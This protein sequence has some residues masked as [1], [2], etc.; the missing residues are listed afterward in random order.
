[1]KTRII[2][3][4]IAFITFNI[5]NTEAQCVKNNAFG[6]GEELEFTG[7]YNWGFIW[8]NAGKININVS[9]TNFQGK[10]AYQIKGAAKNASAFEVF[11]KLRDTL[12]TVVDKYNLAPYSLDR[13]TNEGDYHARHVYAYNYGTET[14]NSYINK[15]GKQN[16]SSLSFKG[17]VN[18]IMSVLYYARNIN[19]DEMQKG[20]TIPLQMLVDGK[21]SNVEI[22]YKGK[23]IIKNK[24]GKKIE[25]YKIT[26]VLPDG[27]MFEGGDDMSVWLTKDKNRV[28]LMVE[29]KIKVGSVKGILESYKGLRHKDN[30]LGATSGIHEKE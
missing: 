12:T 2:F 23:E 3:L 13:I 1:M 4:F 22:R 25:C 7:Y 29:A 30:V 6:I 5:S 8:V 14:I 21:I 17:C 18:N 24:Q 27:S 11:F 16:N 20:S 28:P 15:N 10:P 26:P 19:Y 9:E